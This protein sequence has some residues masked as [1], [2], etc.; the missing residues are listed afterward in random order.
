MPFKKCCDRMHA[1]SA[2]ATPL[3]RRFCFYA[4]YHN[5]LASQIRTPLQLGKMELAK[6][7]IT[8]TSLTLSGASVVNNS[9]LLERVAAFRK[10]DQEKDE[11]LSVR[12][13]FYRRTKADLLHLVGAVPSQH[14]I[15]RGGYRSQGQQR[16][17]EATEAGACSL[18]G[19]KRGTEATEAGGRSHEG[20]KP[21]TEVIGAKIRNAYGGER[22]KSRN[23]VERER[24]DEARCHQGQWLSQMSTGVAGG[25]AAPERG[26]SLNGKKAEVVLGHPHPPLLI[27][28]A[29]SGDLPFRPSPNRWKHPFG[30]YPSSPTFPAQWTDG[31]Y[32]SRKTYFATVRREVPT[33]L[34]SFERQSKESLSAQAIHSGR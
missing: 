24:R 19:G 18:E 21:R 10:L 33:L 9:N 5:A 22:A 26:P 17:A 4:L 30:M 20:R 6:M 25:T 31:L 27:C 2:S 16:R 28:Y 23:L 1:A 12:S 8:S 14:R 34:C 7:E 13:L 29:C 11:L 32:S 3:D 15:S